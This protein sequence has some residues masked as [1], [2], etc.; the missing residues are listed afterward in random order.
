MHQSKKYNRPL[1]KMQ[2]LVSF[3]YKM[4]LLIWCHVQKCNVSHQVWHAINF[5]ICRSFENLDLSIP[6][7]I[8][9]SINENPILWVED[10]LLATLE[11][12]VD[13]LEILP[14][15]QAWGNLR[16]LHVLPYHVMKISLVLAICIR[17]EG[18]LHLSFL[19]LSA[20]LSYKFNM[21]KSVQNNSG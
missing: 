20:R 9:L 3:R 13:W 17:V 21:W 12:N 11:R 10:E 4:T 8:S 19:F 14:V 5:V 18:F 16:S 6:K 15:K 1:L 7:F 2:L